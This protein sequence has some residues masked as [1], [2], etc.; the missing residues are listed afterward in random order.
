MVPDEQGGIAVALGT[1]V[2][3]EKPRGS[4]AKPR[5]I[6]AAQC[7]ILGY[8]KSE[9][10]QKVDSRD[11]VEGDDHVIAF[12][13][14][15]V[16]GTVAVDSLA[17]KKRFFEQA[18]GYDRSLLSAAEEEFLRSVSARGKRSFGEAHDLTAVA[19][20]DDGPWFD[21]EFHVSPGSLQRTHY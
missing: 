4:V 12:A 14:V 1:L 16:D 19:C 9:K 18:C 6:D 13:R 15:V 20:A 3:R 8:L 5:W 17:D 2:G 10:V 11:T 7:C 21:T